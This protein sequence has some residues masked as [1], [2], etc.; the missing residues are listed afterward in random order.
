MWTKGDGVGGEEFYVGDVYSRAECVELVRVEHPL[1]NGATMYNV[2]RGDSS[3]CYAEYDWTEVATGG[4]KE[5][6]NS[7][8]RSP[9]L[10]IPQETSK[11]PV[12]RPNGRK[13][14]SPPP[15]PL[16]E[17]VLILLLLSYFWSKNA[18]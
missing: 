14:T 11:S 1:S 7:E 3:K 13:G 5:K 18:K 4:H 2:A 16:A 10:F 15:Y 8:F 6:I 12:K 9:I 17:E